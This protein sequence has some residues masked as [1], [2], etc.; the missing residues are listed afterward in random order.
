MRNIKVKLSVY[1]HQTMCVEMSK[2]CM[3]S[4]KC[5]NKNN[6]NIADRQIFKCRILFV[7]INITFADLFHRKWFVFYCTPLTSGRFIGKKIIGVFIGIFHLCRM[8][9]EI[10]LFVFLRGVV[11]IEPYYSYSDIRTVQGVLERIVKMLFK[12]RCQVTCSSRTDARVHALAS[13]FQIDIPNDIEVDTDEMITELNEKLRQLKQSIRINDI[14]IINNGQFSAFRNVLSRSYLYRI[15]IQK[16]SELN[17]N[18][19]NHNETLFPIE[20]VDRCYFIK[21]V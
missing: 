20:E 14:E 11:Y 12:K 10:I 3:P 19:L 4:V 8:N 9:A 2:P 6:M 16:K 13:T 5:L 15:A 7:V 17:T 21:F 1:R 18:L